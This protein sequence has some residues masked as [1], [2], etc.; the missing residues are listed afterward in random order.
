[1]AISLN[2]ASAIASDFFGWWLSELEV[3]WQPVRSLLRQGPKLL[4]LNTSDQQWILRLQ[5][6]S[7]SQELGRLDSRSPANVG[8]K[9]LG[10]LIRKAKLKHADLTVLLPASKS[11]RRPL[12][13]PA[14]IESDLRQALYFEIERQTP[15][16]P[17]DVYFGYRILARSPESK[18]LTVEL[19]TAPRTVVDPILR[20]LN[21]W[22]VQPTAVDVA[23][24]NAQNRMGINLLEADQSAAR[25]S[26]LGVA[27]ALLCVALLAAVL[28]VPV[29]QL[30]AEDGSLAAQVAEESGKA[31]QTLAKRAELDETIRAAAFLD[32]R[33]KNLPGVLSVLNELTKALPDNTWLVNIT[34]NQADVKISGYSAAAAELIPLIDAV[35]LFKNPTFASP[36]VQDPVKKLERFDISFEIEPRGG[37]Q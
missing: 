12:D 16:R 33:K 11:L 17:E 1:M 9:A 29:G 28:Y 8:R 15:F 19:I 32:E 7:R 21:E 14:V 2:S 25:W 24:R 20:Q 37:K 4:T 26:S 3:A 30:S 36:I 23:A 18:R 10:T 22:G 27:S 35:P 34:Q 13:L 5:K 6:G 31:K